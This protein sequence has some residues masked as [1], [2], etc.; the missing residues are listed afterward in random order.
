[1]LNRFSHRL[2]SQVGQLSEIE[3]VSI[4][5]YSCLMLSIKNIE[6]LVWLTLGSALSV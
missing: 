5:S 4:V 6:M 1:M 2:I 3:N